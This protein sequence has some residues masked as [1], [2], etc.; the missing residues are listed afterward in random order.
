M[1]IVGYLRNPNLRTR[2]WTKI[3]LLLNHKFRPDEPMNLQLLEDLG[4]FAFSN[5]LMEIS[6]AASSEAGLEAMLKKVEDAWKT[7]DFIVMKHKDSK[8]IFV[9]GSLEEVQ[10]TLDDSNI[11]IQTIAASRHVAPIKP[12]VDDWLKRLDLFTKT[13]VWIFN[14]LYLVDGILSLNLFF[15][16]GSMAILSTAV[17]V[18]GSYIF[19]TGYSEAITG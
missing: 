14:C 3:E 12:R 5:E 18:L 6:G 7:L 11:S 9:L 2:H 16:L 17:D 10:A 19:R 13:L 15:F 1:P 8:D 4:S